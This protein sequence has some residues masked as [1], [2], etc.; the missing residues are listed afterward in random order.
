MVTIPTLAD[1]ERA[2]GVIAPYLRPTPLLEHAGLRELIGTEVHVKHENH[3]PTGAFKVRGGVTLVAQT[4]R[5][6]LDRGL[7][8]ASTGNHGQSIAYAGKLLGA[9]VIICVPVAAN[10]AKVHSIRALGAEI[11]E[12]GRDFD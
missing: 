7:I 6:E 11:V 3:L 12:H 9:R 8:T 10:P 5:D 2:R 4:E 1:I